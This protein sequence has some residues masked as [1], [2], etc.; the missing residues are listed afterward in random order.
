MSQER[1]A[2]ER[3]LRLIKESPEMLEHVARNL[4]THKSPYTPVVAYRMF[5]A[6]QEPER[7]MWRQAT[8]AQLEEFVNM[9]PA[10]QRELNRKSLNKILSKNAAIF[11]KGYTK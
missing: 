11:N 7:K 5:E 10:W 1:I 8:L 2:A 4:Y 6:M 3:T 9:P